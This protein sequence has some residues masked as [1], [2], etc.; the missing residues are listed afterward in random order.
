M[1]GGPVSTPEARTEEARLVWEF[2]ELRPFM[3]S[4][5]LDYR[6]VEGPEVDRHC[7][8]EEPTV[9]RWENGTVYPTWEQLVALAEFCQVPVWRFTEPLA[10]DAGPF[11]ICARGRELPD[12]PPRVESYTHEALAAAKITPWIRG[13]AGEQGRLL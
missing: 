7:G 10:V 6:Q 2:G 9:D 4:L 12:A 8:V 13:D 3:L 11:F 1:R 5:W